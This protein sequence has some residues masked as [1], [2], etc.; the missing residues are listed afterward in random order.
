MEG[1]CRQ[2]EAEV[3]VLRRRAGLTRHV[4]ARGH[5]WHSYVR[6]CV[7]PISFPGSA[8]GDAHD[9]PLGGDTLYIHP[10]ISQ[11]SQNT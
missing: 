10:V 2:H 4:L 3:L 6:G 7:N 11:T 9:D 5:R 8:I 1:V